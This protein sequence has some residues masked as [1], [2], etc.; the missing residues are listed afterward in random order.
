MVQ[1]D[2]PFRR[3]V[4]HTLRFSS[5]KLSI[6]SYR[7]VVFCSAN[8]TLFPVSTLDMLSMWRRRRIIKGGTKS[9]ASYDTSRSVR[10]CV[11]TLSTSFKTN[12]GPRGVGRPGRPSCVATSS[13]KLRLYDSSIAVSSRARGDVSL[14]TIDIYNN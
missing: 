12:P 2:M 9:G 13:I 11:R 14:I 3:S 7:V 8:A 4:V 5:D 1:V 10:I 6:S